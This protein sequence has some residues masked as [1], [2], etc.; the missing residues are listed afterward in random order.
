V[1][2]NNR[3]GTILVAIRDAAETVTLSELHAGPLGLHELDRE[4]LRNE[5]AGRDLLCWCRPG[6]PCHVAYSCAGRTGSADTASLVAHAWQ[7]LAEQ[8]Q[9]PSAPTRREA[10]GSEGL[11]LMER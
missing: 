7:R 11:H 3:S 10:D 6:S 8:P 1:T 9:V 2:C 5:L 4:E